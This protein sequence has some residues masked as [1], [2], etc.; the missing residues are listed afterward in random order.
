VLA[1]LDRTTNQLLV[2]KYGSALET[3]SPRFSLPGDFF[4]YV[5][6]V[7]TIIMVSCGIVLFISTTQNSSAT[8]LL[9]YVFTGE[10]FTLCLRLETSHYL[11]A[12]PS[13]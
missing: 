6:F 10:N 4:T 8:F 5:F 9:P 12:Q 2:F 1:C 11:P 7:A 13:I 3:G